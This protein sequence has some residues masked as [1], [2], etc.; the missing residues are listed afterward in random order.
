MPLPTA[1]FR[2]DLAAIVKDMPVTCSIRGQSFIATSSDDSGEKVVDIDGMEVDADRTIV[3]DS[4]HLP[5]LAGND[6]ITVGGKQYRIANPF[7]HQ[8]GV[9]VELR[10]KAVSR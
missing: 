2:N 8:D 7:Y 5:E 10:L 1:M 6:E 4:A 3:V 9:G